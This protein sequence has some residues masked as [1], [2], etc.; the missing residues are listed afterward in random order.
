MKPTKAEIN[1]IFGIAHM[2]NGY[3]QGGFL[4]SSKYIYSDREDNKKSE[5][6]LNTMTLFTMSGRKAYESPKPKLNP[7]RIKEKAVKLT[8]A[9][10]AIFGTNYYS[11][12]YSKFFEQ[13]EKIGCSHEQLN[14]IE[15]YSETINRD[16]TFSW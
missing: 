2:D 1:R 10:K 12:P 16:M 9:V 7:D 14:M 13:C 8:M 6:V 5:K 15:E 3:A 11:S 4:T